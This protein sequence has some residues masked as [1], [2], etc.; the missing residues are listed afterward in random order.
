MIPLA[1]PLEATRC[2]AEAART[3]ATALEASWGKSEVSLSLRFMGAAWLCNLG[4]VPLLH[5]RR[6]R[7]GALHA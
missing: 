6:N 3:V 2:S 4:P 1:V 7:Q 5:T